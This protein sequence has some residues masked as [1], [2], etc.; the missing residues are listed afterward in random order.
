MGVPGVEI[1]RT[2]RMALAGIEAGQFRKADGKEF[3]IMVKLDNNGAKS[4]ETLDH[5]YIPS[6]S[7]SLIP[8]SQ[9][10]EAKFESSPTLIEHYNQQRYNLLSC[11]VETGYNTE[12]VTNEILDQI[13]ALGISSDFSII[14]SG[15]IESRQESF[16]GIGTAIL[17]AI[18]G[19]F[20]ILILEFK[21][22]KSTLIVLS[23]IP[24]GIMGGL[25]ALFLTGYSLSFA[26]L[27]DL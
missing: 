25:I 11:Y 13:E 2:I 12:K 18:F 16:G 21:T 3:P 10:A 24:L 26:L 27:L 7:G 23:V 5:V 4:L 22:F 20:S 8:L 17:I 19:V 15:E 1:D 9:L 6:F 14:P